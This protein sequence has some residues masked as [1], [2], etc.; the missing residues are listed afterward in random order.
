MLWTSP[1]NSLAAHTNLFKQLGCNALA[2][3]S[4]E[5]AS[6][7][8]IRASHSIRLIQVPSLAELI[9]GKYPHYSYQKTYEEAKHE[10]LAAL[11]TS[12]S[13]GEVYSYVLSKYAPLI[14]KLLGLPKPLIYTHEFG[15]TYVNLIKS[16]PPNGFQSANALFQGNRVLQ[17]LPPFHVC[18]RYVVS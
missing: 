17:V 14:A 13:T 3:T 2:T 11:H 15:Y 8:N 10:P 18:L 5:P 6:V 12:G 1:L 7:K 9:A 16:P 4:P